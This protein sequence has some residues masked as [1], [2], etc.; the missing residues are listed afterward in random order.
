[1]LWE[2]I[3]EWSGDSWNL[4]RR[5]GISGWWWGWGRIEGCKVLSHRAAGLLSIGSLPPS[6]SIVLLPCSVDVVEQRHGERHAQQL[7]R[8]AEKDMVNVCVRVCVHIHFGCACVWSFWCWRLRLQYVWMQFKSRGD[9][10]AHFFVRFS[11]GL[12]KSEFWNLCDGE[13]KNVK[14]CNSI[15]SIKQIE[16]PLNQS[17]RLSL[18]SFHYPWYFHIKRSQRADPKTI[19]WQR[20]DG[21]KT[22]KYCMVHSL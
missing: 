19:I 22:A 4:Y 11:D 6:L 3:A 7:W 12:K 17:V 1:M 15:K 16:M 18:W 10:R 5:F 8:R 14:A 21:R 20:W 13:K 2:E 9:A